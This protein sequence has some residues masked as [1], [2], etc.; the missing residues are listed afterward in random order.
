MQGTGGHGVPHE[1]CE[2]LGRPWLSTDY[3]IGDIL[4]FHGHT[5]HKALDNRSKDRMRVSLEY[6]YQRRADQIDPGSMEFHMK[7]AF[8]S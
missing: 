5:L 8:E 2:Q 4:L 3:R 6:R 1:Q 7:G